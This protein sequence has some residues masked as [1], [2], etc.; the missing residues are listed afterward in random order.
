[1]ASKPTPWRCKVCRKLVK[2][3]SCFCP[4]CG[5]QW[6]H[7]MD[8]G[9]VHRYGADDP[10]EQWD[11]T[12]PW[13]ADW[14]SWDQRPKSPR[15]AVSPR[16]KGKGK[17]KGKEKAKS[18]EPLGDPF[19]PMPSQLSLPSPP[20]MPSII[21]GQAQQQMVVPSPFQTAK[22]QQLPSKEE[23]ELQSL[24][25]LAKTLKSQSGL[26]EEVT[27]ALQATEEAALKENTKSDRDLITA[28][29]NARK[30]LVDL[31]AE[32]A[33]YRSQWAA[34]MDQVSRTWVEQAESFEKGEEA[35]SLKRKEA[36]E[37]IQDLRARLHVAHQ[38]TMQP[39]QEPGQDTQEAEAEMQQAEDMEEPD[40]TAEQA[41]LAAAR[42]QMTSAVQGLK[43]SI[44][45]RVKSRERP[46]SRSQRR[47]DGKDDEE[48]Q[49]VEPASKQTKKTPGGV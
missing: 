7:C 14:S 11:W 26:T 13:A 31:D 6:D 20:S 1:M 19:A 42:N 43:E 12:S 37:K 36:V 29:G 18:K 9:Y 27:K 24:R 15:R 16:K 10:S 17:G 4:H 46:R 2:A 32:W 48:V 38:K 28:L 25:M 5:G 3:S 44:E 33:D 35:F 40:N 49:I 45:A 23:Q 8:H 47:K 22:K 41:S 34:Y 21:Q 39:G 30:L